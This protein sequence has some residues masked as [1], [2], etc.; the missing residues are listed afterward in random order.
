MQKPIPKGAVL[1]PKDALC[2][3]SGEIFDVYQWNQALF[4][5]TSA[6]FEM[7]RRPDT[8]VVICVVDDKIIILDETQPHRG[9]RRNFPGGRVD[10][11]DDTILSAA[12]REVREETGYSFA[13][14]RLVDVTQPIA[15]MEWFIYVFTAWQVTSEGKTH[16]DAGEN[17]SVE[18]VDFIEVKRTAENHEN[19]FFEAERI[20]RQVGS[21]EELLRLPEFVGDSIER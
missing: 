10:A 12:K 1:I 18:L 11:T 20:F 13:N 5:D 14:W 17:I 4:D 6:V 7:V 2:V 8:A 21:V 15:K 3:Y 16:H 9:A 19:S